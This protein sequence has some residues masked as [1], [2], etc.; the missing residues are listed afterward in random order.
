[1]EFIESIY[2]WFLNNYPWFLSLILQIF[3]AY[4]IFFLSK[5]L[6]KQGK[7]IHKEEMKRKADELL[8]K[9]RSE[10][11]N[12]KVYLVNLNRYFK[13]YPSNKE[14]LIGGYSH[15]GAEIKTTH[16][17][18]IE[19]FSEM[20]ITIYQKANKELSFIKTDNSKVLTAIPVGLVP[21]DWIDYIDLDGDEYG[22]GIPLIFCKFKGE[23]LIKLFKD[24]RIIRF[25]YKSTSYY[26]KSDV[27]HEGDP[28][29][30]K[31]SLIQQPILKK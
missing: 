9:I 25:P 26:K 17:N 12:R 28:L 24:F 13:D 27:Y 19:F 30:M 15:I 14:K 20:Q 23:W 16:Y 29:D 8:S 21:Y 18:G 1:M 11:I 6:S 22:G 5:R 2:D 31:Y 3:I 4:H 7:L 10:G